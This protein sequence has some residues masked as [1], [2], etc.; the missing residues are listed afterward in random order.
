MSADLIKLEHENFGLQQQL[1][2]VTD[3]KQ[4]LLEAAAKAESAATLEEGGLRKTIS[5]LSSTREQEKKEVRA[6]FPIASRI[7]LSGWGTS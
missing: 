7:N 4:E 6:A 1:K 5:D 3:Q 2:D